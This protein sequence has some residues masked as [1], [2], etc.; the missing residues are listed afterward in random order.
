MGAVRMHWRGQSTGWAGTRWRWAIEAVGISIDGNLV[1][2]LA[3]SGCLLCMNLFLFLR[4]D[5]VYLFRIQ[6]SATFQRCGAILLR[7][8]MGSCHPDRPPSHLSNLSF[9]SSRASFISCNLRLP[10]LFPSGGFALNAH[11]RH[12]HSA[13]ILSEPTHRHSVTGSLRL[14]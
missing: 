4:V 8:D 1:L 9:S 14:Q 12:N 6:T 10:A 7:V 13:N 5:F 2:G 11:S 3:S